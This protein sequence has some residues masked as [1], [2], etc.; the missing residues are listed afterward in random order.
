MVQAGLELPILR[1]MTWNLACV[2]LG[3]ELRGSNMQVSTLLTELL[4]FWSSC[5]LLPS[6][7]ISLFQGA[8]LSTNY[9]ELENQTQGLLA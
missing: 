6:A 2:V 1:R 9:P 3:I 7:D 5:L 4:N 8:P